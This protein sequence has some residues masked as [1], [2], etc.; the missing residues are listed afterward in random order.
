MLQRFKNILKVFIPPP[1]RV[2]NREM[3]AIKTDIANSQHNL[4]I[5]QDRLEKQ[6]DEL[7][8]TLATLEKRIDIIDRH[9][10]S[11]TCKARMM[12]AGEIEL[13]FNSF[14]ALSPSES[15][16]YE[17]SRAYATELKNSE[18]A[19]FIM[20]EKPL[21]SITM[22]TKN[23]LH[24]IRQAI[25]SILSQTYDNWELYIVDDHSTDGTLDTLLREYTHKRIHL[26]QSD[27]CGCSAAHNTALRIARGE[28]IAHLDSDNKW[29]P[30]YLE[31]MLYEM[32]RSNT[33]CAYAVQEI[34]TPTADGVDHILYR[35]NSF[36]YGALL[37]GNFIDI[38]IFMHHRMLFEKFGG[39]DEKLNRTVDWDLVLSYTKD[40]KPAFVNYIGVI[41]DNSQDSDRISTTV[42]P[43]DSMRNIN[44]IR[45]KHWIDWRGLS[46]NIDKRDINLTSVILCADNE[47][48]ISE[49]ETIAD[50]FL[51][52]RSVMFYEIIVIDNDSSAALQACLDSLTTKFGSLITIIRPLE[53]LTVALAIDIGFSV[54]QGQHLILQDMPVNCNDYDL[55][56]ANVTGLHLSHRLLQITASKY[57]SLRDHCASI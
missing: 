57:I 42:S 17:K 34:H 49:V 5:S 29:M 18:A 39:F 2:F 21:V 10:C 55:K 51:S 30:E 37:Y 23:R 48:S 16:N 26:V 43:E 46:A 32:R 40:N 56:F 14:K 44:I 9:T 7:A 12:A 27:G 1:I 36:D 20:K 31:L 41:Y 24:C 13:M 47:P 4:Q 25:D 6:L 50:G 54:S 38:N 22:P 11:D 3:T 33:R 8:Q 53:K 35:Q 19:K 28:Y 52:S 15:F 45:A